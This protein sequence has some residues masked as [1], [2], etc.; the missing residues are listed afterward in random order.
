[1]MTRKRASP[2]KSYR[3]KLK[4]LFKKAFLTNDSPE[5][6]ARGF[7]IGVF[8]GV[9]PTFGFAAL[10]SIPMAV[11]LKANRLTAF[12][13][14]F[15]SNPLTTPFFMLWGTYLGNFILRSSPITFSWK[16][17]NVEELLKISKSLFIGT[18]ILASAI[19]LL[20]Y[21]VL[22]VVIP[23]IKRLSTRKNLP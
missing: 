19:S 21:G 22:L 4:T 17:L 8:W 23:L 5:K 10:F 12:L 11:V 15:I 9:L 3:K 16:I 14:T 2:K 13:G 20:S 1:M 7:A 6:L 18:L